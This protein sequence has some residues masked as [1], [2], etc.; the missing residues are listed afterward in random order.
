MSR[1]ALGAFLLG[2]AFF[3]SCASKPKPPAT[4]SVS[5]AQTA[6]QGNDSRQPVDGADPAAVPDAVPSAQVAQAPGPAPSSTGSSPGPPAQAAAGTAL[7]TADPAALARGREEREAV[8]T[9]IVFGSPSSLA[10]ARELAAQ[11]TSIKEDAAALDALAKGISALAYPD[12]ERPP[13]FDP[14]TQ[15]PAT[16]AATQALLAALNDAAAGRPT[17]T[18]ADSAGT[19]LGELIPALVLFGSDS[20]EVARRAFDALDRFGRLGVPSIMPSLLR[21]IDSERH[22]DWQGALQLY[23]SALAIAPDAWSATLGAG[24]A[25][26]ALKRGADALAILEPLAGA[27]SSLPAFDRP[28]ALALYANGR[29][30]DADPYVARVLTR[31]PQ[32][33]RFV[34]IRA[35]LLVRGG[36]FQLALPLLDAYGTVD[37]SNRLYLLLRSLDAEGLRAHDEALKWARRGLASYPDDP[38][39]LAEA[40]RLLF[41]GPAFGHEEARTLAQRVCN[42]VG[43]K[44][45]APADTD[46]ETGA[47]VLAAWNAAGVESARLLAIDAASRFK[48]A[49][50]AAYLARAGSALGDKALTARILRKSGDIKAEMDFATSWYRATPLSEDAEEAYLRALV[51]SGDEK[52][53]QDAIAR[54]LPGV[55]TPALR[56]LL[57]FLQSRLQKSD[58]A[59]LN[60]LHAALVENADNAEALAA[61]SD[62]QL[63]RK[64][65]AKARFYL[66]QAI[67]TDPG[68]PDLEARQTQLDAIYPP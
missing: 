14:P 7:R 26:L 50:A 31:D 20:S 35:R 59:A 42:L 52:S 60:L 4:A 33:S 48:W 24:R 56:S 3:S 55:S 2:L 16:S 44:T 45:A 39:L 67:A 9:Q 32:D 38:E 47:A 12:A 41:A 18:P 1:A 25:L 15:G 40:S 28:Y 5:T 61:V 11:A 57:Y 23:R 6:K 53:A 43:P 68:D 37:S 62:I 34:L 30:E 49:D 17:D 51:D 21:G 66:K 64:D 27:R 22:A 46:F 54:I 8:E 29:Y 63:R 13:A 10:K 19:P 36:A 58:E 65:Y